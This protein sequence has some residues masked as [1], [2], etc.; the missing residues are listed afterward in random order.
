MFAQNH[1]AA[2]DAHEKEA[3]SGDP[4]AE[5]QLA[6]CYWNGLG[7]E[8][9]LRKAE[10][11]LRR[12]A[13]SGDATAMY[14]L[15]SLL[16]FEDSHKKNDA[17]GIEFLLMSVESGYGRA[18]YQ[19]GLLY[20]S[21]WAGQPQDL[22]RAI[23]YFKHAAK[24]DSVQSEFMLYCIYALGLRGVPPNPQLAQKYYS[25]VKRT[26]DRS[27]IGSVLD[28]RDW[29]LDDERFVRFA[30]SDEERSQIAAMRLP[31]GQP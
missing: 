20:W 7:R 15:G 5:R 25:E 10:D 17:E 21:G 3:I 14:D 11:L 29:L 18:G 6:Y 1:L 19:L 30:V 24:Y 9:N 16:V 28:V 31:G 13:T 22:E 2:C 4:Y 12:S 27:F 26:A 8:K 23:G